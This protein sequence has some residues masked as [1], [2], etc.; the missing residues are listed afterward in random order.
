MGSGP[1]ELY[2]RISEQGLKLPR[3]L[4]LFVHLVRGVAAFETEGEELA[5]DP[6]LVTVPEAAAV[7]VVE[8]WARSCAGSLEEV[9]DVSRVGGRRRCR[10]CQV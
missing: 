8:E 3:Q 10:L 4:C 5:I 6:K 2:A 7:N 1:F 9:E